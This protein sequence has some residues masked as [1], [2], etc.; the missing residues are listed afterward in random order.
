MI[1]LIALIVN[2][3]ISLIKYPLAILMAILTYKL[4][5]IFIDTVKFI[6]N[7]NS[8]YEPLFYGIG[9]YIALWIFIFSSG[10]GSWFLTLEHEL[11]HVIFALLTF[12]K[13]VDFKA[14]NYSGG[15]TVFSGVSRGNW[16][17]TIAPY[18]FPTF[19]MVI[20][21]LL[22]FAK[23]SYYYILV[24]ILG[25]SIIYH[26][27][28]TIEETSLSQPD[29]QEVGLL[30]AVLFLP[31]ANLLA[32]IGLLSTIPNDKIEFNSIIVSLYDYLINLS[33]KFLPTIYHLFN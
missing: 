15:H 3:I 16:L 4:G 28:S 21:G 7:H 2:W 29:I 18:F 20:V 6:Y 9:I 32:L 8:F 11:T 5:L 31:G 25:Y 27:H 10:K 19:S 12:H 30:F 26:I 24:A 13:I 17:I 14:S 1:N 23:S 33:Q 22:Y